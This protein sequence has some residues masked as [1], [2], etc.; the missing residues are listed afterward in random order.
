MLYRIL[1]PGEP[2]PD[3][4]VRIGVPVK[5]SADFHFP[6]AG[7]RCPNNACSVSVVLIEV[8][9]IV[10]PHP[11]TPHLMS[12]ACCP[13]CWMPAAVGELLRDSG[14]DAGREAM[15]DRQRSTSAISLRLR[16]P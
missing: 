7:Y 10:V 8:D 2:R 5:E 15:I 3:N 9:A 11:R 12:D 14:A 13:F 6:K 4:V 16:S 1:Q